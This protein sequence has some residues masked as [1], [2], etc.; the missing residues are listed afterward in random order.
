[1]RSVD[2]F[3][4]S[5]RCKYYYSFKRGKKDVTVYVDAERTPHGWGF[6]DVRAYDVDGAVYLTPAEAAEATRKLS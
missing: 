1:M 5:N 6:N 3:G 4:T 2:E